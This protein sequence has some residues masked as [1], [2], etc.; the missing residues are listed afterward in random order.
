MTVKSITVFMGAQCGNNVKY[1]DIA[2]EVGQMIAEK[3]LRLVYGGGRAGLMG[4]TARSAMTYDGE[5]LGISP[6]NLAEDSIEADEITTLI[7]VDT[8][9][10]RKQLLMDNADA[11]IV[12]P[13]GF[14]TLEELA[15]VI[16]WNRIGL[17]AKPLILLNIDGFYDGL[18]QW[19]IDSVHHGFVDDHDL[20][21]IQIFTTTKAALD[22]IDQF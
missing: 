19:I 2:E 18:W 13:G 20:E 3:H 8:M 14:G 9:S 11:F 10:E 5:V 22:Y 6:R 1:G 16:S 17:H 12:L 4:L 15:Q 21:Y 7:K